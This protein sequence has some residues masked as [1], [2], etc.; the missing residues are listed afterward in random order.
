MSRKGT[1]SYG[2]MNGPSGKPRALAEY[3]LATR[4]DRM[5]FYCFE[6]PP[7]DGTGTWTLIDQ[8]DRSVLLAAGD[9]PTAKEWA[10]RLGLKSW[11]YVRV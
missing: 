11:T 2:P 4:T 8:L 6:E 9:K 3:Y 1:I 5:Q 10:K 7:A